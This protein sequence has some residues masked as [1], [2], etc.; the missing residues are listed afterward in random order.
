MSAFSFLQKSSIG[1]KIVM[2]LTGLFLITFLVVHCGINSL[3]FVNDGGELFDEAAEFMATNILIRTMEIGLFVGLLLHIYQGLSLVYK[4]RKARPVA[5]AVADGKANSSWY[6]RS[7]G[8]LGTILLVFLIIHLRHFWVVSRLTDE[9]TSG[10]S[11][12]FEEML[13]VFKHLWIVVLYT[14]GMVSLS[15][16]LLHGF[17]SAFQTMGWNHR[18]YTPLIKTIGF[19]FSIIIPALFAAMPISMYMGWI[20]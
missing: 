6:S 9:I 18:K 11:T 13:E 4:N 10:E 3:I 7:M 16:H 8:L 5:Y 17:Q 2:G 14:L 19:W 15:Y 1:K 12:L 20:K